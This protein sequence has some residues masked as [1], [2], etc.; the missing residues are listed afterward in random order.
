MSTGIRWT[1]GLGI[2]PLLGYVV[3]ALYLLV[4]V[5]P[6]PIVVPWKRAPGM[7]GWVA[8]ES[9]QTGHRPVERLFS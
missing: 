8:L 7:S 9:G 4:R 3:L 2:A 5:R 6:Q 1:I